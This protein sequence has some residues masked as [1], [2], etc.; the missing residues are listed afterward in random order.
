MIDWILRFF[1]GAVI[2][3]DFV[4]P[5]ISGAALAV[6]FGLYEK[7]VMFIANIRKDFIKNLLFFLPVGLGA[8]LGILSGFASDKLFKR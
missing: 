5:G 4:L 3:M 6:V 2:G 1:K 8:L 7:I